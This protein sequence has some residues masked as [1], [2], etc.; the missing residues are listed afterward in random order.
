[1]LLLLI[2]TGSFHD[3]G[4]PVKFCSL[5]D[6]QEPL[7]LAPK[8][9]RLLLLRVEGGSAAI[10]SNAKSW[11]PGCS[12]VEHFLMYTKRCY[13]SSAHQSPLTGSKVAGSQLLGRIEVVWASVPGLGG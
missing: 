6:Y 3:S 8:L 9:G 4:K 5:G 7:V 12:P 1:M 10:Y 11:P 13:I 2:I